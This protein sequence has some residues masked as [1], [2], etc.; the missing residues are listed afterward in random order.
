MSSTILQHFDQL[1]IDFIL[2]RWGSD[3]CLSS[4]DMGKVQSLIWAAITNKANQV[5]HNT[6][7]LDSLIQINI[8]FAAAGW[9]L[10]PTFGWSCYQVCSAEGLSCSEAGQHDHN[11]DVSTNS[12]MDKILSKFGKTCSE[13]NLDWRTAGDVPCLHTSDRC[14]ISTKSRTAS[15]YNCAR[16]ELYST[17]LCWCDIPGL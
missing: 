3:G 6:K 11:D 8:S 5:T 1:C 4:T 10:S 16:A 9:R 7:G 2:I 17:R 13:Y 12:G 15:Q 14:Y